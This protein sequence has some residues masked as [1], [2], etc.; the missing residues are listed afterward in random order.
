[1]PIDDASREALRGLVARIDL[2]E[3]VTR[4]QRAVEDMPEYQG[5]VDGQAELDDRGPA[6]IRWNLETFLRWAIDGGTP[7]P[8]E[9]QRLRELIG[10]RAAEGRA[11]EEG[12]AVYRRALRAGWEAV[13]A[14]ADERERAALGGAFDV[15]LEWLEIV[16]QVFEQAYAEERDALV[17]TQ[18]R[19][20]RR[21]FDL[22]VGG[23]EADEGQ[24]A[25]ALGFR[26]AERYRPLVAVLAGAPI[27]AAHLRL[28]AELRDRG[29]L[30]ISEGRRVVGLAHAPVETGAD[31][32][33]CESEPLPRGELVEA[34][35]DLRTAADL[36]TA[37]G[38]RGRVDPDAR[39]PELLLAHSPRLARRLAARVFDPLLTAERPD[40]VR[41]V[42]LLA[43][44]GFERSA[45]AAALPV[46]RNTLLQRIARIEEL[47]G[48]DLDAPRD[49]GLVWLAAAARPPR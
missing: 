47:T 20:A 28:A 10:A 7:R 46:H 49:R 44:H 17:S 8:E 3:Y 6:G 21:L 38:E 43:V 48:L 14:S 19:R 23:R 2:D 39:L 27:G 25:D 29:A 18:E 26:L 4:V 5:F 12:L 36:A 41:T 32:L 15:V 9:L 22:V 42:E 40:L 11:P 34:L 33:L 45:T 31:A 37:A 24:L 13:L 30:A 16:S 1:V 35:A